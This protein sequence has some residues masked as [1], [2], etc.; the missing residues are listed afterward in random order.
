MRNNSKYFKNSKKWSEEDK[1][2]LGIPRPFFDVSKE[3]LDIVNF[4][5]ARK[6]PVPWQSKP[7]FD[8]TK[9][10]F[11]LIIE[12]ENSVIKNGL[13][14]YCG[15]KIQENEYVTRW[16]EIVDLS[17]GFTGG[18][19]PSDNHPL[20]LECMEQARIFCPYM[21]A[22]NEE[23]FEYGLFIDLQLRVK[24]MPPPRIG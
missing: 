17:K 24:K 6:I 10:A 16:K 3:F 15:I 22:R 9:Q 20:H 5:V 12:N 1:N 8:D 7:I 11:E 13:C 21:K 19:V 14:T 23:E 2:F 18:R 4:V